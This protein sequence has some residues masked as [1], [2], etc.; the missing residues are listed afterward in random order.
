MSVHLFRIVIR[1]CSL[2][3]SARDE[4]HSFCPV[5]GVTFF[6][7][8][9]SLRA[10][11]KSAEWERAMNLCEWSK[12]D[13]DYG[14]KLLNSGLEGARSGR[15]A[16]LDGKPLNPVL[17]ESA[18]NALSVAAV[19][20]CVGLLGSY[21][22]NRH[23][24]ASRACAFGILGGTIGFG[25]GV[26]WGNRRL[27]ASVVSGAWKNIGRARDEHWLERNPIDYA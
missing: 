16:F 25:A 10:S 27:G 7:E 26:A 8:W 1:G 20:A 14:C 22:G 5:P 3:K 12:A 17:N 24:S 6:Q 19:G 21:L 11:S 2:V 18:R 9:R 13:F 15:E 4:D 23:R